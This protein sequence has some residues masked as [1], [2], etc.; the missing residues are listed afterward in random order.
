M[1]NLEVGD[2]RHLALP[3]GNNS[4]GADGTSIAESHTVLQTERGWETVV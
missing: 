2:R 1:R 3:H 4:D